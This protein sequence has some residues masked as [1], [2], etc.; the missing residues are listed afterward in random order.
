MK[1]HI[2]NRAAQGRISYGSWA[3]LEAYSG[4]RLGRWS[5]PRSPHWQHGWLPAKYNVDPD[6]IVGEDGRASTQREDAFFVAR[7]DQA[8]ALKRFGF[9]A[10]TAIGLPFNYAL[11]N[12][13]DRV[14]RRTGSIL[15][16]P[17]GH[18]TEGDVSRV[19]AKEAEYIDYSR[20]LRGMFDRILVLL[21]ACDLGLGRGQPWREAGFE[22]AEG[23]GF[24][25]STSLRRLAF[26]FRGFEFMTTNGVG[27][28]IVYAAAAGCRVSLIGPQPPRDL[29]LGNDLFSRNRP[30]LS[31]HRRAI[32]KLVE[33]DLVDRGLVCKPSDAMPQIHWAR[34]E[35][36]FS[37]VLPPTKVREVF[38]NLTSF[39]E[40]KRWSAVANLPFVF[41][42]VRKARRKFFSSAN[43]LSIS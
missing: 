35:I 13:G 43:G 38:R 22:V 6:F 9:P 27:S 20:E 5:S 31:L 14:T 17:G 32:E 28:H 16:M 18:A 8:E 30:D 25:D 11:A 39:P 3:E 15:I 29:E 21:H 19:W 10:A 24:G 23:A 2:R 1:Q 4:S 41:R 42:L 40:T 7:D 37:Q 33:Q 34:R 12:A 26:L 36:G